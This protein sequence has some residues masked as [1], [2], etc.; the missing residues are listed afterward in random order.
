MLEF[1][2]IIEARNMNPTNS[3]RGGY[4][5]SELRSYLNDKVYNAFPNELKDII[6]NTTAVSGY[7]YY[8]S[9]NFISTDKL[10][11][12]DARELWGTSFNHENNTANN[13]ER[14]LDYYA[15]NGVTLNNYSRVV[16]KLNGANTIW[17]LRTSGYTTGNFFYYVTNN[18]YWSYFSANNAYGVSP[19]FRIA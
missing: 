5:A 14:Q 8:D 18:G 7:G 10:Y 11:L 16:K 13:Y 2:D 15:S 4:P 17:W 1:T 9:A 19:A 6:I 12:L 3:N